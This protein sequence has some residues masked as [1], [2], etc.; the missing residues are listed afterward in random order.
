MSKIVQLSFDVALFF[1]YL[2][3]F[4]RNCD[5]ENEYFQRELRE[6]SLYS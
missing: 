6:L 4:L 2:L 3:S 5:N 1:E